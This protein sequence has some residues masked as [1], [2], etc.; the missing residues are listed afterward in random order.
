MASDIDLNEF[1]KELQ[2]GGFETT[3]ADNVLSAQKESSGKTITIALDAGGGCLVKKSFH[4]SLPAKKIKFQGQN[5]SV[6]S[7]SDATTQVR[8]VVSQP[9]ELDNLIN[10]L[11]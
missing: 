10:E 8:T 4:R 6:V 7:Y 9:E 2:S 1:E 3:L 5:L 11:P